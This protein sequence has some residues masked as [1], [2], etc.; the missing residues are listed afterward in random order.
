MDR[1]K[2]ISLLQNNKDIIAAI[3]FG[4]ESRGT[5]TQ[6]SDIDIA[7]LYEKDNIPNGI[8]LLQFRQQLSDKMEQDVDIVL[9]NKAS[10]II[11][12]QALKNGKPL[13]IRNQKVYDAFE[14]QLV[15]DYADVK[16]MREPFEK[17]I[18]SRKLHD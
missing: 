17:N 9:L 4:S 13:L 3:L 18:L 16:R 15:T 11:S 8:D 5:A 7:L 6:E 14:I 1:K 10:P 12:M 2:L